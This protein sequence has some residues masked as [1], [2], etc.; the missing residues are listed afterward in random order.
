VPPAR[1]APALAKEDAADVAARM[2]PRSFSE[3]A[4]F[5]ID[6]GEGSEAAR[7][8]LSVFLSGFFKSSEV[9]VGDFMLDNAAAFVD[10]VTTTSFML[11]MLCIFPSFWNGLTTNFGRS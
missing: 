11:T 10:S 1:V 8:S 6:G 5:I 4:C 2:S 3:V 7:P 9:D